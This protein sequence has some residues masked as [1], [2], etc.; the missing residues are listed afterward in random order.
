L[1]DCATLGLTLR[2]HPLALLRPRLAARR[3]LTALQMRDLPHGCLVRACGM[4]T[5]RQQPQTAKGTVFVTL[6]DE[7][8][9]VNVIVWKSLRDKQ[10]TELVN[11]KLMAVF[12][13]WQRQ[14]GEGSGGGGEG[15][16]GGGGPADQAVRHLVAKRLVDLTPLLG[17]LTASGRDFG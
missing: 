9:T 14:G 17:R 11:A 10:R 2:R 4:V 12:G 6:E 15:S 7:T 16:A 13:V 8:G 5:M 3:L 1:F